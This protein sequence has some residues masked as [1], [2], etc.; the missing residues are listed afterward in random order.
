MLFGHYVLAASVVAVAPAGGYSAGPVHVGES[1]T[2][3]ITTTTGDVPNEAPRVSVLILTKTASRVIARLADSTATPDPSLLDLLNFPGALASSLGGTE[4]GQTGLQVRPPMPTSTASPAPQKTPAPVS[5]PTTIDLIDNGAN[6]M[7]LIAD[8]N[9]TRRPQFGGGSGGRRGG[10][11][12]RGGSGGSGRR[13]GSTGPT[14]TIEVAVEATFD[15]SGVLNHETYRET[16]VTTTSG[17]SH[18][19]ERTVTIDRV[20]K[21]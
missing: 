6:G 4:H 21:G 5:V 11:W 9:T 19:V 15:A 16:F 12:Q 3:R 8:G 2:Y 14:P 17:S 13:D 10:G 18:T 7:T 1:L 20:E